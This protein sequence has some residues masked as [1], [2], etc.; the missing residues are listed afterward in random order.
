MACGR[1]LSQGLQCSLI[2]MGCHLHLRDVSK[3][4]GVPRC[5]V[6]HTFE[7]YWIEGHARHTRIMEAQRR[8]GKS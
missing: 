3:Y 4:S 2:H 8:A 1:S 7:D 5:I 6:Q